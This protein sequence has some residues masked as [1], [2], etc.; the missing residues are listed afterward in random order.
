MNNYQDDNRL[1]SL[2]DNALAVP[3]AEREEWLR[4]ECSADA[5]LMVQV[6]DYVNAEIEMKQFLQR[7]FAG[8]FQIVGRP[9]DA[10]PFKPPRDDPFSPGESLLDRFVIVRRVAEGGMGI[11]YEAMDSRLQRRVAIKCAKA[12]FGN[13]LP[14]EV[15]HAREISHPN[16]CRIFDIHTAPTAEGDVDFLS[17]EFLEGQTLAER[18]RAGPL[19]PSTARA[20]ARQLCEGLA[21]AH[22]NKVVHGDLKTNN[23]ILVPTGLGGPERAVITDFGLARRP[24][25]AG[26]AGNTAPMMSAPV[27]GAPRYMAPE[28]SLGMKPSVASDVYAVGVMLGEIVSGTRSG[29][30]GKWQWRRLRGVIAR[31]LNPDPS[32]RFADGNAL[33]QAVRPPVARRWAAGVAAAAV[34]A[35]SASGAV[36]FLRATA[37]K[38]TVRL[39]LLP[40][41]STV[42]TAERALALSQNTATQLA[43]LRGS[44]QTGV[45]FA[46]GNIPG[47]GTIHTAEAAR[48]SFSATHVVR[49]VLDVKDQGAENEF[50][51]LHVYIT[52]TV[53][54]ANKL[55]RTMEYRPAELRYA[56]VAIAGLVTSTF[57]LPPLVA[58][59]T[60]KAAVARDY[61]DGVSYVNGDTRPEDAIRLLERVVLADPDS[62]LGYAGLAEAESL[63]F[64][65]S[66]DAAWT[67]KAKEATRQAELRNPDL[68]EVHMIAGWLDKTSGHY[69]A[70]EAHFLRV[71]ALQPGNA[72]AWRRLGQTYESG[73]RAGEALNALKKA[74]QIDPSGF[75]NHREL[76]IFYYMR[77]QFTEAV[78]EFGTMARLAPDSS[79][80][81]QLLG[82]AYDNMERYSEAETEL[83]AAIRTA[84]TKK[85]NSLAEQTLGAVL[86]DEK[87][88]REATDHYLKALAIGPE[89]SSLW[90][91][92]SFCYTTQGLQSKA[93]D[94]FRRGAVASGKALA[95]DPRKGSEHATL[96]YFEAKLHD[97]SRAE[98]EVGEALQLSRDDFTIQLAVLTYESIGRRDIALSLLEGS[99]SAAAE[100]SK[101]PGLEKFREEP[102]YRKLLDSH[103]IR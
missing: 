49:A 37:P 65:R 55:E 3:Q 36:T 91:S 88:D 98:A 99:P 68:P 26:E 35:A 71:V 67:E 77:N 14:P 72:A 31:C 62:A 8:Y 60:V 28:L 95:E 56:P 103:Q 4:R 51:V 82:T 18:L 16:V 12:G 85:E 13:R 17:M 94:A 15:R 40:F 61:S 23:V 59:A 52:D 96:A 24:G 45:V 41:E 47:A 74:V 66:G 2:V 44:A 39:A 19:A 46:E 64:R 48:K 6:R 63:Q 53:S 33:V 83:E 92:L 21:E 78:A 43:K 5:A 38:Q 27:G 30:V 87:K 11:V 76:G 10:L 93:S 32:R 70:A 25:N 81:H 1:M 84:K 79:A 100:L 20:I 101:Y 22:R 86:W 57:G 89:T 29:A 9:L 54:G 97:V 50:D 7:P 73:E 102:R 34:I 90:R 69:E 75:R 58:G 80:A 42:G